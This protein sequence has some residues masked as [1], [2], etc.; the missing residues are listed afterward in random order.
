ML[1]VKDSEVKQ[2]KH[3]NVPKKNSIVLIFAIKKL[4]H[5]W[6]SGILSNFSEQLK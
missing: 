4:H 2:V 1:K 6:F 3:W 5:T